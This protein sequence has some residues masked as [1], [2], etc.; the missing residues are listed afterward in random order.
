MNIFPKA[1]FIDFS[2]QSFSE[3]IEN[4]SRLKLKDIVVIRHYSKN[5]QQNI[6]NI[7][8]LAKKKNLHVFSHFK[9]NYK[10]NV[11]FASSKRKGICSKD[12]TISFHKFNDLKHLQIFRPKIVFLSPVFKTQSHPN[13]KPLG[14][15]R[16]FKI[17]KEI[18]RIS[19]YAKIF[20]LG[21]M[22]LKRFIKIKQLD[23]QQ[24]ITG[25]AGIRNIF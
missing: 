4:I 21:G 23:F 7:L 19:P 12:I 17:A 1:Y 11:H 13:Q 20:L 10:Q 22:T 18:K 6:C 5:N 2:T 8:Q 15:I 25:F 24:T 14:N 9:N 16:A 3:I